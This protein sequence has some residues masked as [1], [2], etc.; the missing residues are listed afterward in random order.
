MRRTSPQQNPPWLPSNG[1]HLTT[2][3]P[4]Q[5]LPAPHPTTHLSGY[6]TTSTEP[7]RSTRKEIG[8]PKT[9]REKK[10]KSKPN[11]RETSQPSS[12][13]PPKTIDLTYKKFQYSSISINPDSSLT[14]ITSENPPQ[15]TFH[16]RHETFSLLPQASGRSSRRRKNERQTGTVPLSSTQ[17]IGGRT[18]TTT[19]HG[20]EIQNS[21]WKR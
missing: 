19:G 14:T 2:Y 15:S 1:I 5:L 4:S 13:S 7:H 12:S 6:T 9:K 21:P 11:Q 17:T 20:L 10:M 16:S 8:E 18:T 3:P